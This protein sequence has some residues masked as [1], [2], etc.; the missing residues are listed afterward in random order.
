MRKFYEMYMFYGEDHSFECGLGIFSSPEKAKIAVENLLSV[1]LEWSGNDDEWITDISGTQISRD[2]EVGDD[3]YEA[4]LWIV[5]IELDVISDPCILE[6][7][8]VRY[9]GEPT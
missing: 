7:F 9:I 3:D 2:P 1:S 4:T 8:I 5:E 6:D